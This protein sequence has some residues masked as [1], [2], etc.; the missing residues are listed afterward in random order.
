M[1]W[2]L[3]TIVILLAGMLA[4]CNWVKSRWPWGGKDIP[5]TPPSSSGDPSAMESTS[6]PASQPATEPEPAPTQ[7]PTPEPASRSAP[8]VHIEEI[9]LPAPPQADEP[10]VSEPLAEKPPAPPVEEVKAPAEPAQPKIEELPAPAPPAEK[11]TEPLRRIEEIILPGP[12]WA[13]EPPV[14]EPLPEKPPE[15]PVEEVKAPAEPAQPKIEELP[16]PVPPAEKPPEP[17]AEATELPFPAP[18]M[19]APA[20]ASRPVMPM[21]TTEVIA[22]SV[23]QVNDRFITVE[24]IL[25]KLRG[26]LSKLGAKS[27]ENVFRH[28]AQEVIG[29]KVRD[30]IG[31]LLVLAEASKRLTEPQNKW[32][33]NEVAQTRRE[34]LAE[35]G[36]SRS[37]LDEMLG[38]EGTN[39]DKLLQEHRQQ[40]K[41]KTYL[42]TK[43]ISAVTV[44]RRM[45]WNYYRRH[46][47]EFSSPKHVQ[48]QIIAVP[49]A[50]FLP[51]GAAVTELERRAAAERAGEQIKQAAN[52][53]AA[54]EEF[55]EVAKRLSRGIKADRGGVWPMMAAGSFRETKVE[56]AAFELAQGQVSDVIETDTGYYIAKAKAIQPGQVVS[57][58]QAQVKI[59]EILRQQQYAKL[60]NEYFDRLLEDATII[61]SE[62]F[63]ALA[64]DLAVKR[65]LRR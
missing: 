56:Q 63:I 17:P 41:I 35:A 26:D 22:A 62:K 13:G 46:R 43:F 8:Q 64:V 28:R 38:R 47:S 48:M 21:G 23:L 7:Q 34:L 12:P 57:F 5:V 4:G 55:G 49:F 50:T 24:E 51:A 20:P 33:D 14:P 52:A 11:P 58:E 27:P 45:L 19:P 65:Y 61:E 15:S 3:A 36:G 2:K 40:L 31:E 25:H 37:R 30:E 32:I 29:R 60:T 59:D 9:T 18:P 6:Q 53:I 54:G 10:P 42:R 39:L 1:R 16:A 44:N